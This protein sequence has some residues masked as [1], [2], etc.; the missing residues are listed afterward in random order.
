MCE[1]PGHTC[2][3]VWHSDF[4]VTILPVPPD[5]NPTAASQAQ[6]VNDLGQVVG[7]AG[8]EGAGAGVTEATLWQVGAGSGVPVASTTGPYAGLEGTPV[9]FDA[10]TSTDPDGDALTYVWSFGDGSPS[11]TG[12]QVTHA[13][14]D[15]GSPYTA[16]L[17][18]RD[19][20]GHTNTVT[21]TVTVSNLPPAV[22]IAPVDSVV[23]GTAAAW[24]ATLSDPG[25]GDGSYLIT[26]DWG[27]GTPPDSYNQPDEGALSRSHTYSAV[28]TYSLV[29]SARDRD[30]AVGADTFPVLVVPVDRPPVAVS[31]GPYAGDEGS[32][33]A[34]D[35]AQSHDIDGDALSFAWN[36]G[37]GSTGT[38]A[39]PLHAFP[40][41]GA[42]TVTLVVTDPFGLSSTVT[43][44]AT[45]GNIAPT[46]SAGPD[47]TVPVGAPVFPNF[48][49]SDPG[50]ADGPWAWQVNWGSGGAA[51]GGSS[52]TQGRV[53]GGLIYPATG[54]YIIAFRVTDRD[55][56]FDADTVIVTVTGNLP[57][58]AV[59]DGPITGKEGALVGFGSPSTDPNND[60]LTFRWTFGDGGTSASQFPTHAYAD[61]GAYT[62]TV[63]VKDPKGLSNTATSI[64][65]IAN[66][67]PTA[68]FN[69]PASINEGKGFTLSLTG[70][71]DASTKDRT[72]GFQYAFD[73]G[74]G[75]GAFGAAT[76]VVCPIQP[77]NRTLAVSGQIRD[78]DGG[79]KAYSGSV[80]VKNV[81]PKVTISAGS[82]TTLTL[83]TTFSLD[84]SFTDPGV[85]D[86]PWTYS[87]AWGDGT[88]ATTGTGVPGTPLAATHRF[89]KRGTWTI[90][91][92]V[93]DRN[94]GKGTSNAVAVTVQ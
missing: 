22:A 25:I 53:G 45:I 38:G 36:F 16:L 67:P 19:P 10:S 86:A 65:T 59:I 58:H 20:S 80:S 4:S 85:L 54:T 89:N 48:S 87:I 47:V 83:G 17:T 2:A 50:A 31:G 13:Y 42:Y 14:P 1:S 61:N 46:A 49:F 3:A 76:S 28:G 27:D 73:C 56:A 34:F 66:V 18:A 94:G 9:S 8:Y 15:S 74:T 90:K 71:K 21:T 88:S 6:A 57:P 92:T 51:S 52:S 82:A 32:P 39:T 78:K 62:V 91:M 84:G 37:D 7:D 40:G 26:Y 72:A 30:L 64:A 12:T 63:T 5:G 68:T 55:G 35:A 77:D 79:T 44:Q 75:L 33:I 69:R 23:V 60:P 70:A 24:V 81:V 41:F 11:A 29:V 43:T 93:T